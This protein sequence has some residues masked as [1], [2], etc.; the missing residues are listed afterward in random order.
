MDRDVEIEHLLSTWRS[1]VDLVGRVGPDVGDH[2]IGRRGQMSDE[3][4]LELESRV[5]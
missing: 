5:I 3:R 2:V 1:V 4:G